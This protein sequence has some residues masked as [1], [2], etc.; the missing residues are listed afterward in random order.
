MILWYIYTCRLDRSLKEAHFSVGL[1]GIG[2]KDI[3]TVQDII[4][5][6]FADV[7]K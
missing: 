7:H 2:E 5:T 3:E 6:T 4:W 1:F